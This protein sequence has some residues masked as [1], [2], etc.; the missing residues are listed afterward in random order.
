MNTTSLDDKL[1]LQDCLASLKD[2]ASLYNVSAQECANKQLK[3]EYLNLHRKVQD[4]ITKVFDEM[5]KKG[6]YPVTPADTQTM[7]S[8]KTTASQ[9]QSSIQ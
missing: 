6:W 9:I 3:G 8:V 7:N 2:T 1:I 5:S 4:N